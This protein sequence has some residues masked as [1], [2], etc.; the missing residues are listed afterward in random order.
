MRSKSRQTIRKHTNGLL[1]ACKITE[2]PVNLAEILRHLEIHASKINWNEKP[3]FS[4]AID[5]ENKIL[6]F[7]GTHPYVRRRFS[8]AHEIGHN[9]LNH[10]KKDNCFNLDSSDPEE[11]EANLFASELLLPFDWLK[12]DISSGLR[13]REI[14]E[15]YKVSTVAIG[16]RLSNSDALL[17]SK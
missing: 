4:A 3:S 13:I 15:K 6:I 1:N 14:G 9:V 7:N 10:S 8:I 16:W 2:P 12:K 17:L 5:N 11:I